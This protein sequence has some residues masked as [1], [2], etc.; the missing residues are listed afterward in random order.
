MARVG[1][2]EPK[3]GPAIEG[4]AGRIVECDDA[5]FS[6]PG[7]DLVEIVAGGQDEQRA[8]DRCNERAAAPGEPAAIDARRRRVGFGD[9]GVGEHAAQLG[10][11]I[12]IRLLDRGIG[13]RVRRIGGQPVGERRPIRVAAVP[14]AQVPGDR[15]APDIL[16]LKVHSIPHCP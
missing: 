7:R 2:V 5:L 1:A 10:V 4:D 8:G 13:A 14:Q 6:R 16:R 11:E 3:P 12:E 9:K 15:V